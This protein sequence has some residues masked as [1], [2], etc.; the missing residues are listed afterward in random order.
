M[1]APTA[2]LRDQG[3]WIVRERETVAG[4]ESETTSAVSPLHRL[5]EVDMSASPTPAGVA[6]ESTTGI[7]SKD[8]DT[9][10]SA[11]VLRGLALLALTAAL[12]SVLLPSQAVAAA[13]SAQVIIRNHT[14]FRL[15]QLSAHLD[16][17]CWTNNQAPADTID[18]GQQS[19]S[20]SQSCGLWTG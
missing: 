10:V 4:R 1:D 20:E 11:R 5:Q 17:G 8:H 15:T 19:V 2:S 13:R 18:P 3:N 14:P 6:Q 12:L 9:R 16:H 7:D